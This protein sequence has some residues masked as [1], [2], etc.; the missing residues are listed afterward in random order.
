M[1]LNAKLAFATLAKPDGTSSKQCW[2][3]KPDGTQRTAYTLA[4][5]SKVPGCATPAALITKGMKMLRKT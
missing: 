2:N 4:D 1:M 5:F 3:I